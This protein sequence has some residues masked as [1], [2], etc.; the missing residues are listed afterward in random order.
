MDKQYD[1]NK[2]LI[3]INALHGILTSIYGSMATQFNDDAFL[4]IDFKM[5]NDNNKFY[6]AF[7][8][9]YDE[10]QN[11]E[12]K[13]N[14]DEMKY[15]LPTNTIINLVFDENNEK[16][17][18]INVI[19][20]IYEQS[21]HKMLETFDFDKKR[22]LYCI[23]LKQRDNLSLKT[24][25]GIVFDEICEYIEKDKI[26][27][28][29]F[30]F[31]DDKLLFFLYLKIQCMVSSNKDVKE[32][33]YFER[34]LID[35]LDYNPSNK[36]Y[37]INKVNINFELNEL[38]H[39]IFVENATDAKLKDIIQDLYSKSQRYMVCNG[40]WPIVICHFVMMYDFNI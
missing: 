19:K 12:K 24:M 22:D 39:I 34:I 37:D 9:F 40:L 10:N 8:A 5:L 3:S 26:M 32:T 4:F 20:Q 16:E 11:Q 13:V 7:F 6:D 21:Q 38:K 35:L 23:L 17:K 25:E 36:S 27:L 33:E 15:P 28:D 31:D 29:V 1:D 2:G 30:L 14:E 18:L